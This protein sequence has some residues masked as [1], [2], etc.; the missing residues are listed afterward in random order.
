[1]Q[2]YKFPHYQR[3]FWGTVISAGIGAAAS[4]FG[5]SQANQTNIELAREQMAFQERMSSTAHQRAVTDLRSAGLN[6]ILAAQG[7]AS[8]PQGAMA[9]VEDEITPGVSSAMQAA[10]VKEDLK[11]LVTQRENIKTDTKLKMRQG[12]LQSQLYEQSKQHTKKFLADT[13]WTQTQ[14]A[15]AKQMLIGATLKGDLNKTKAGPWLEILDRILPTV[16]SLIGGGVATQL[17]RR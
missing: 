14:T 8:S 5:Q 2:N 7:P 13:A 12:A 15:I 1:M 4:Y 17:L 6:P 16:K 10:R 11:Q 3:G 9:R